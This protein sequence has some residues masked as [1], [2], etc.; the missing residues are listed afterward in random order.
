MKVANSKTLL[1]AT[2]KTGVYAIL[3]LLRFF[4]QRS[5]KFRND[6]N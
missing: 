2:K 6:P 3:N 1:C 5:N 4:P